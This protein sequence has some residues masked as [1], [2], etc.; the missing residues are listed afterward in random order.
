MMSVKGFENTSSL[1]IVEAELLCKTN[2]TQIASFDGYPKLPNLV[3]VGLK[4]DGDFCTVSN[5]C[6]A[7]LSMKTSECSYMF[8]FFVLESIETVA[9]NK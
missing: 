3:N 4:R 5:V 6:L 1:L 9:L 2:L 7:P 8:I